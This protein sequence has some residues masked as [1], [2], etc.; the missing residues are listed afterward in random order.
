MFENKWLNV[1]V[2]AGFALQI[3]PFMFK[4]TRVFLNLAT[5]SWGDWVLVFSAGLFVF[6]VIEFLKGLL[7]GQISNSSLEGV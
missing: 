2:V 5:L 7:R 4:E 3:M 6:V 1:A